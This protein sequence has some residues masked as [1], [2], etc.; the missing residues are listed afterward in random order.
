[1]IDP[2]VA[3]IAKRWD[4][5]AA[6][7]Q[8]IVEASIEVRERRIGGVDPLAVHLPSGAM[9]AIEEKLDALVASHQRLVERLD[10]ERVEPFMTRIF[11]LLFITLLV[12]L[13]VRPASAQVCPGFPQRGVQIIDSLYNGTLANGTDDDRRQLTRTFIEQLAFEFPQDGWTWKSADPGRPPSKDSIARLT[14]GRLCN[15]DWQ[16]G[17][18]RQRSVQAGQPGEDI[19]GQNPIPVAR[20]N[21]LS[22]PPPA[23][24]QPGIPP[25]VVAPPASA[26]VDLSPVLAAQAAGS[27]Q[28]ELA[29]RDLV[30]RLEELRARNDALAAQLRAHDENPSWVTKVFGNRYTQLVM[31]AAAAWF[32]AQQTTK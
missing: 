18:T 26:P 23:P 1:M 24:S 30:A 19:T 7:L 10:S 5:D 27:N 6:L 31:G 22:E 2:E 28:L 15:W 12:L 4:V 20:L 29:Y 16:N 25:P 17:S 3:K 11:R 14:N 13:I 9:R 21:H 8:A 32:T